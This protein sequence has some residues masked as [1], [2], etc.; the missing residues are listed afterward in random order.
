MRSSRGWRVL[1]SRWR[2]SRALVRAEKHRGELVG[3]DAVALLGHRE[4]AAAQAGLDVRQRQVERGRGKGAGERRVGI[5][6]DEHPVGPLLAQ[7]SLDRRLHDLWVGG[8]QVEP[9]AR[10]REAELL[11]EDLRKLV[12]VVLPGVDDDLVET[13]LAEGD[14]RGRGLNELGAVAHDRGDFHAGYT[15]HRLGPLAQLVEQGTLNPKVEGSN[16]SR[17]IVARS[18]LRLDA[19]A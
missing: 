7:A 4:V 11:E 15:T 17:P 8:A 12:V 5:A 16:P 9:V 10:L 3:L 14:R 13:V 6:V 2:V 18:P 19:A 1:A